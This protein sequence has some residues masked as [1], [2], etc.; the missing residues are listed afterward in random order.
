MRTAPAVLAALAIPVLLAL[1]WVPRE[2]PP[3]WPCG[4]PRPAHMSSAIADWR[5]G[6]APA[7]AITV[8]LLA[9][10]ALRVSADRR[11]A[12]GLP[13]RPGGPTTVAAAL[14]VVAAARAAFALDALA[15]VALVLLFAFPL[16]VLATGVAGAWVLW[17]PRGLKGAAAAQAAIWAAM[18]VTVV[19]TGAI[20]DRGVEASCPIYD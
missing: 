15:D 10:L 5:A 2:S 19:V 14:S 1:A 4:F 9:G 13:G 18:I 7:F 6:L 20:A 17:Q 12:V 3:Q 8:V 11:R 16:V